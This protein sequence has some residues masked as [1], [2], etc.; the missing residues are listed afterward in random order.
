M[1]EPKRYVG[2]DKDIKGGMTDTGKVIR[3]AW[4]FGILEE[5]ETCEGWLKPG[6]EDLWAK[7]HD[8]W[9]KY[10]FSVSALPDDLRERFMRIQAE[11]LEK[12]K[13]AGWSGDQELADD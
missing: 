11:A 9:D 6:I 1:S 12:A 5:G 10:G 7:V 8:E 3:D 2:L 13:A 4:V